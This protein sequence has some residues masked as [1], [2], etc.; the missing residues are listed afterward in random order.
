MTIR[1]RTALVLT[2]IALRV[3]AAES[4]NAGRI[5]VSYGIRDPICTDI[6]SQLTEISA[7]DFRN[8]KWR[9][10]FGGI[11]WQHETWPVTTASGSNE[12]LSFRHLSIDLDNDRSMDVVV[13]WASTVRGALFDWLYL[14]TPSEFQAA[15]AA[16]N[17]RGFFD[18]GRRLNPDNAVA[19]TN[20][21]DA[22]PVE[23]QVWERERVRYLLLKEHSF[24][25]AA[26]SQ[27]NTFVVAKLEPAVPVAKDDT[28]KRLSPAMI[29]RFVTG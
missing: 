8:G 12:D 7:A 26:A 3:D 11:E 20:G 29:C 2:A 5:D 10:R 17:P 9:D 15:S 27:S 13:V 28:A 14:L 1:F 24:A 19:F 4:G 18:Q 22:V 23:L 21:D 6:R 25:K 16:R